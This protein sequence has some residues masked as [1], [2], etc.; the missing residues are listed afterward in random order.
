MAS[1]PLFLQV[2]VGDC[3][4]VEPHGAEWWVGQVLHCEGGA[5]CQANS[6]FQIADVD[7]GR[8]QTVNPNI[9]TGI[10]HKGKMEPVES[11][12]HKP[13]VL[14]ARNRQSKSTQAP[15]NAVH[16]TVE[17]GILGKAI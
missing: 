16:R 14:Q 1:D 8:I 15:A 6:F 2:Q 12:A 5:R 3:V 4:L 11:Q 7:T 10:V 17:I 13:R 9:V